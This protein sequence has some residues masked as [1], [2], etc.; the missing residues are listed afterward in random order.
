MRRMKHA[1]A[2][3]G[4]LILLAAC[5]EES[6]KNEAASAPPQM[7]PQA[8]A[9]VEAT[10]E[11]LPVVNELP[12]RIAPTRIA[13]V[14]PRVSGLIIER[15]FR[16]GTVVEAGDPLY[17]IDPEPFQVRADRA[18]AVLAQAESLRVAAQQLADRQVELRARKV[19][20]AQQYD[21]AVAGLARANAGVAVAEAEMASSQID[22]KH[23]VVRAPIAGRI[24]RA[25]ITEGALV[26][27]TDVENLATIQQLDPIYADFTQPSN[28]LLA[29]R[30]AYEAGRL[31][32]DEDG[33]A[34]V[35]LMFDDDTEYAHAGKL[36]FSEA[37]VDV[38]TGQVTLRGEFPNPEGDLLPGMY[39]RVR[40]QQGVEQGALAVPQQA[41]QRDAG[42]QAQLYIVGAENRVEIRAVSTGR[43]I[44]ERWVIEEGLEPG[45]KV[46]VEG[47][48]KIRPGAIVT[49][50]P[51]TRAD[52]LES[53]AAAAK[54]EG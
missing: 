25:R 53:A 47:F 17:R 19:V 45:D 41:V 2:A 40:I 7:P 3:L 38:T 48:Q 32:R 16:Q 28:A 43:V 6:G 24:G 54:R 8:V 46:I 49:P 15:V 33:A 42:G 39:V 11:T 18:K 26:S 29:L 9:V 20:S 44:G 14:R 50:E 23:T 36:L 22:L 37:T 13:E 12:G 51:W 27:P 1:F 35:H 31:E 5:D 21:D 34:A 52:A 10:P 30:R 4:V